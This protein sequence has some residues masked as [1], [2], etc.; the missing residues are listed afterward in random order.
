M[1]FGMPPERKQSTPMFWPLPSGDQSKVSKLW[2]SWAKSGSKSLPYQENVTPEGVGNFLFRQR[3]RPWG[4]LCVSVP[5][6]DG[7]RPMEVNACI[8]ITHMVYL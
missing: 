4:L 2:Y 6:H 3:D 8:L 5:D 7:G 1:R